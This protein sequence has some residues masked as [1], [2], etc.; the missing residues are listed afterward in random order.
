GRRERCGEPR[1]RPGRL[2]GRAGRADGG[3]ADG[4]DGR[5]RQAGDPG[6]GC[7]PP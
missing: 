5:L 3:Q 6:Q 2:R 1:R 4:V 7:V